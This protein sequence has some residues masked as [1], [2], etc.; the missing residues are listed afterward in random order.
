MAGNFT[1]ATVSA[2]STATAAQ[3]N[4]LRKDAIINGG[5]YASSTGS[6][7]AYV[8]TIDSAVTGSYTTGSV[9]KFKANF[10]NT[11]SST[12]NVNGLGA[13]TIVKKSGGA[14]VAI[15]GGDILSG[16]IVICI[17]DGTN[18]QLYRQFAEGGYGNGSDGAFS[19]TTAINLSSAALVVKQYTSVT[20]AST[21]T[22]TF[23][24]PNSN[25]TAIVF[26]V[27]GDAVMTTSATRGVDLRSLG[28]PGG[29]AISGTSNATGNAG[30]VGKCGMFQANAGSPGSGSSAGNGGAT[31]TFQ[32]LPTDSQYLINDPFM[33]VG[34][35]GGSGSVIGNGSGSSATSGAGGRAAGS[36]TM[37]VGGGLNITCV[38]DATGTAGGNASGSSSPP[39][40]GGGGG[41]AGGRVRIYYKY[42]IANSATINITGGAGGSAFGNWG[43]QGGGGGGGNGKQGGTA[44][45]SGIPGPGGAG[46]DGDS[47]VAKIVGP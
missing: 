27:Q 8:L 3:F 34:A 20:L 46:A 15:G 17:Y 13:K 11:G 30:T 12:L 35:G 31:P 45:T 23:T 44:G 32:G 29:A 37:F 25:G 4:G 42:L 2:A 43:T 36:F 33:W 5:D 16:E 47:I 40:A 26:L 18:M 1:Q 6:A 38:I 39:N 19:G 7:N 41:G 24:N 10:G 9:F 14:L 28:A 21:D 22:L